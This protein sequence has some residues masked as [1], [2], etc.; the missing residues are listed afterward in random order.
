MSKLQ[1]KLFAKLDCIENIGQKTLRDVGVCEE[2]LA[3]VYQTSLAQ[4]ENLVEAKDVGNKILLQ[5]GGTLDS[6]A[7]VSDKMFLQ[8]SKTLDSIVNVLVW[9]ISSVPAKFL[10]EDKKKKVEESDQKS[11]NNNPKNLSLCCND[12]VDEEDLLV[13]FVS[14]KLKK[15]SE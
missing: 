12:E 5:V 2:I 6:I 8:A 14:K 15:V 9:S 11:S 7:N 13:E 1:N 3:S 4:F 10:M